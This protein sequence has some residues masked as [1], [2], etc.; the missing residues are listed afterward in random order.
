VI[1]IT[2]PELAA[3]D[4]ARAAAADATPALVTIVDEGAPTPFPATF[5]PTWYRRDFTVTPDALVF[6]DGKTTIRI[7]VSQITSVRHG[8]IPR[9]IANHWVIVRFTNDQ[10]QPDAV[11]FRDGSRIG[12]GQDTR[13]MYLAARRAAKK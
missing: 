10:Q 6:I 8:P 12:L 13:L 2:E 9:D 7:P 3:A 5:K 1:P 4:G 11:A